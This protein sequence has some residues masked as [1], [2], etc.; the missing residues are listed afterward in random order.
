[1]RRNDSIS[2][3]IGGHDRAFRAG[4]DLAISGLSTNSIHVGA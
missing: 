1:M 4:W 2:V 3:E